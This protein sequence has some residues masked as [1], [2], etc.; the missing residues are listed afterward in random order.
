M[1]SMQEMQET[2]F[3]VLMCMEE[4][5]D[6][7]KVERANPYPFCI[8][9]V[10][11]KFSDVLMDDLPTFLPLNKDVDHKIEVHLG[12]TSLTKAPYRLN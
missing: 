4:H 9:E 1:V 7:A 10:I 3:L 12:S 6:V 8:S 5:G 11:N 2:T